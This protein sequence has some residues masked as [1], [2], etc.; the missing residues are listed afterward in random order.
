MEYLYHRVPKH[1]MGTVLYPLNVLKETRPEIY[2]EYIKKY[3]GREELLTAEV[4][5]SEL[6]M[7]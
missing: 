2:T 4:P 1:M 6:L 3:E 7:E 5:P